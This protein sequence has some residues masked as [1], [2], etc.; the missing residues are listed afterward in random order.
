MYEHD[1]AL[2]KRYLI[3]FFGI[4]IVCGIVLAILLASVGPC[5]VGPILGNHAYDELMAYLYKADR[6]FPVMVLPV[7]EMLLERYRSNDH[8][9][10]RGITAMPS[11]HV[12]Q[13]F[14][15]FLAMRHK[16][17]WLAALFGVFALMI[18]LGSVHLAYHYAVDGYVSIAVTAT[19][20]WLAG[21]LVNR[22]A[23]A[24]TGTSPVAGMT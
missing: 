13:A 10:G 20:W 15:F 21:R 16:A 7:Q 19:I 22:P 11:L 9:L 23:S 18:L 2:R 5:F 3:S 12:A 17:R 6:Q 1:S 4:W 14:L 24:R 8:G